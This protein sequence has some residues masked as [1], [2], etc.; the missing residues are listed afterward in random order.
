MLDVIDGEQ[1]NGEE[2]EEDTKMERIIGGLWL[3]VG[4]G[5]GEC[6]QGVKSEELHVLANTPELVTAQRPPEGP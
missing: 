4:E 6:L 5:V 2:N 3:P 1:R